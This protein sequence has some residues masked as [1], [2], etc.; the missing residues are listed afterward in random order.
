MCQGTK[1]P[2]GRVGWGLTACP[3]PAQSTRDVPLLPPRSAGTSNQRIL[4]A[5]PASARA[6]PA[7]RSCRWHDQRVAAGPGSASA[8]GS[9]REWRPSGRRGWASSSSAKR[10]KP[11]AP[12]AR[13]PRA[14]TAS[15]ADRRRCRSALPRAMPVQMAVT[16]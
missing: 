2:P 3:H 5:R 10:S 15:L 7:V 4:P 11:A 6:A 8:R 16:N 13:A 12:R 1:A 9:G 14:P